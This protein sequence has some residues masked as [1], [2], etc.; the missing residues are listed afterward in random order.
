L[1]A[2]WA[3]ITGGF[4][5]MSALGQKPPSFYVTYRKAMHFWILANSFGARIQP[6]CLLTISSK[7]TL[8]ASLPKT[9]CFELS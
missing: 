8:T 4:H 1:P 5:V 3:R 9:A 6:F 2:I 7:P